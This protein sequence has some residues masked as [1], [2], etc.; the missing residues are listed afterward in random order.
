MGPRLASI[1][2]KNLYG[3]G[4]F[5]SFLYVVVGLTIQFLF[6]WIFNLQLLFV[7]LPLYLG[8]V[9][10]IGFVTKNS[11]RQFHSIGWLTSVLLFL[12]SIFSKSF[13]LTFSFEESWY[14]LFQR[15]LVLG[16]GEIA[17]LLSLINI[18]V[19]GQRESLRRNIGLEN[20]FFDREKQTWRRKLE[21]FPNSYKLLERLDEGQ[22]V[23]SLFDQGFFNLT[24]LWS[25]NVME[26]TV[27]AVADEIISKNPE[28]EKLFRKEKGKRLPYPTQLR[29]LGYKSYQDKEKFNLDTLWHKVRNK[30]AHHNYTPTFEETNK[31]LE[32]LI[33]F[34]REMPT[35]LQ[36]WKS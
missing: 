35:V 12:V 36:S 3:R 19:I 33:S 29:N 28:K 26:K 9:L 4:F 11:K 13:G 23:H 8:L 32:I 25:C 27:D 20:N 15:L 16:I 1:F 22:F 24:I 30:I 7:Y 14:G 21:G 5:L 18:I 17:F 10:V 2:D 6:H 34:T 31:T